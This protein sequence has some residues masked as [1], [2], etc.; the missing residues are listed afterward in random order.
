MSIIS[1][2]N[3][4][5]LVVGFLL[6]SLFMYDLTIEIVVEILHLIFEVF[7]NMF[8][9]VEL[10]IEHT[11]EHLFHTERHGSQVITFY[12]LMSLIGLGLYKLRFIVPRSYRFFK[13]LARDAWIR[14]KIQ[15]LTFWRAQNLINKIGIGIAATVLLYLASFFVM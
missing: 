11:V 15:L 13:Q 1:K 4:D 10:G 7:H 5:L 3:L 9:W 6:L 12:T 14:R 8:E 2:K